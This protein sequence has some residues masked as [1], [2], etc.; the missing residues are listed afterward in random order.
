MLT[1][2]DAQKLTNL[3]RLE[4]SNLPSEWVHQHPGGWDHAA[5]Q[6]LLTKL[7]EENFH[8]IDEAAVGRLVESIRDGRSLPTRRIEGRSP[9]EIEKIQTVER[10]GT[11][12]WADPDDFAS[13]RA[14]HEGDVWLGRSP[15]GGIPLGYDDDRHM[16]LTCGTRGGKGTTTVLPQHLLWP[17]SLVS[18]DP[19]GENASVAAARRGDGRDEE[20]NEVCLG[21]GQSVHV[22][23]PMGA[24][25]VPSRYRKRF[26]P[27]DALDPNEPKFIEKAAA[28]AEAMIVRSGNE[29]EDYWKDDAEAALQAVI[30]H[31]KTSSA[32]EG[33][34]DMLT[35]RSLVQRGDMVT[36]QRLKDAGDED[37]PDPMMLL[38]V[39][40][41]R[42][43]ACGDII[44]GMGA[45]LVHMY[46]KADKQWIGMKGT[47]RTQTKFLDSPQLRA[48]L[49]GSDFE[50]GD[51][52]R[53]P[54]GVSLFM[55][56]PEGD[57][58][59]YNRWLRLMVGLI[60]YE[61][62]QSL[63]PPA[64][65]HR[66]LMCLDEFAG[67]ERMRPIER[68]IA[69][70]AKYG[71]KLLIVLQDLG[72]LKDKYQDNWQTFLANTSIKLFF[73]VDD[74]FT[75]K[76]ISEDIGEIEVT[77]ESISRSQAINASYNQS[78]NRSHTHGEGGSHSHTDNQSISRADGLSEGT[79]DAVSEGASNSVGKGVSDARGESTSRARGGS[80][81]S[82]VSHNSGENASWD[83]WGM[84]RSFPEQFV[85]MRDNEKVSRSSGVSRNNGH[86]TNW[87]RSH[88]NSSTHTESHNASQTSSVNRTHTD[89]RT[90][91]VTNTAS[92]GSSDTVAR[93]WNNASTE[94][95]QEGHSEGMT[96]TAGLTQSF[97]KRPLITPDEIDL[98]LARLE[99]GDFFYPGLGLLKI[100][101]ERWMVVQRTNYFEDEE[102]DGLWDAHPSHPDN[103]P[104]PLDRTWDV[105]FLLDREGGLNEEGEPLIG[106]WHKKPGDSVV[107]G[108]RLLD[109]IP[110]PVRGRIG[111][112]SE[113]PVYAP[114]TGTLME[115][116][117]D[118]DRVYDLRETL[119]H[120]GYHQ[121]DF[122]R[123][124]GVFVA[125]EVGAYHRRE[126]PEYQRYLAV[127]A[128]Q[129]RREEERRRLSGPKREALGV[130][131]RPQDRQRLEKEQ[132]RLRRARYDKRSSK[133]DRIA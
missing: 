125:D 114:V 93:N 123:E 105:G 119:C 50:L 43:E 97:H 112:G 70:L 56:L 99:R 25:S 116:N 110:G 85:L 92:R 12:S 58:P 124:R 51:L 9:P 22:L 10:L 3:Q 108:E 20:G 13:R 17:G 66:I 44:S 30:L 121:R 18:V 5:F 117:T 115:I 106:A 103:A 8:P 109:I 31:V 129:E 111:F 61:V 63:E 14:F 54:D 86:G 81:N 7:K 113:I 126:H 29:S 52:K 37:L 78:V 4:Q 69:S 48:C 36:W 73:C 28:L 38:L 84:G 1:G 62:Q 95:M 55:C 53:D 91:T 133:S 75:R 96:A 132:L 82:G 68:G 35:V 94:G 34:R 47:L 88:S 76:F 79:S 49:S 118:T 131:G 67:L 98:Y 21:M 120:I 100:S 107:K 41:K 57:M 102:L 80:R 26:N 19:T 122:R 128:K 130:G 101:G 74:P 6:G 77:K 23:D 33:R 60:S 16:L 45:D 39:M 42:N 72:Q 2:E 59:S 11:A 40:M 71:V 24:A 46:L 104:G 65:G 32:F 127:L 15:I 89:S 83:G 64:R 90:K 87:N 27:L